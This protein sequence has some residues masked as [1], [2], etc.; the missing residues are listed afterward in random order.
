[1]VNVEEELRILEEAATS[2]YGAYKEQLDTKARLE[3]ENTDLEAE[4]AAVRAKITAHW[5]DAAI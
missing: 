2:A 3:A 1:M 5:Q 4:L